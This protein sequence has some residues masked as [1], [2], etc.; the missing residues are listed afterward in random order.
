MLAVILSTNT[1]GVVTEEIRLCPA[2]VPNQWVSVLQGV[3]PAVVS[4]AQE[5]AREMLSMEEE[6]SSVL[7]GARLSRG[8]SCSKRRCFTYCTYV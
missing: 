1:S 2:D 5:S 6:A 7:R 3:T 8:L 4:S